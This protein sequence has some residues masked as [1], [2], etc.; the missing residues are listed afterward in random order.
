[1]N[2]VALVVA[3]AALGV[4]YDIQKSED[5]KLEYVVQ[6]EPELLK[7]LAEGR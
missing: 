4:N 3:L 7:S 2:G 1:M 6:I 5:N